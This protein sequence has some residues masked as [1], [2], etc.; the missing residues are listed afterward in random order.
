MR[1]N[2]RVNAAYPH[3]SRQAGIFLQ[4]SLVIQKKLYILLRFK[5]E[6][7]CTKKD[8]KQ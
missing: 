5:L 2:S 3:I 1:G 6:T 7:L 4:Y 8:L